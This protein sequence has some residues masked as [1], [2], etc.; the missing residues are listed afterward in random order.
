MP[1]M[2]PIA[3]IADI[4]VN[5]SP[6]SVTTKVTGKRPVFHRSCAVDLHDVRLELSD[7][8][9]KPAQQNG[10]DARKFFKWV[11]R[12]AVEHTITMFHRQA[13]GFVVRI[14]VDEACFMALPSQLLV[15]LKGKNFRATALRF[16]N[17][18][19]N[20]QLGERSED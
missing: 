15:E 20:A 4:A 5:Q 1:A 11:I 3:G 8:M 6:G 16:L 17:D 13:A 14:Q 12:I 10:I 9:Q 19:E 7:D 18:L 2:K